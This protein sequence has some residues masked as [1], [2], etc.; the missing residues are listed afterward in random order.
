MFP[1]VPRQPLLR[2]SAVSA[3]LLAAGLLLGSPALHAATGVSTYHIEAGDLDQALQ[4]LQAQGQ[5]KIEYDRKLTAQRRASAVNGQLSAADALRQALAGSGLELRES[6]TGF[7]L[8]RASRTD[9]VTEL[10]AVQIVGRSK[11]DEHPQR[12]A[13][14]VSRVRGE[15]LAELH[16]EDIHDLQ[17]VVPGLYIQSTDSND[18]QLSIRGVGDGGGQSSGDQNIGM[19]SSVATYVDNVYYPRPGIIRSLTDIDYVDVFKGPSGTLFGQNATGGAV[20]IHTKAPSF[21]REGSITTTYAGRNTSKVTGV[22][23]G[24]VNDVT[25]FRVVGFY[26]HSDG[27]VKNLFDGERINGYERSGLRGQWLIRPSNS[28]E[29][30]FTADYGRES[31]NPARVY[32]SVGSAFAASAAKIGATYA[33]GGRETVVDDVTTTE[34]EYGGISAEANWKL[35]NGDKFRSVTAWRRYH[36][37]PQYADELSVPIYANSGTAVGDSVVSQDFRLESPRGEFFDYVAGVNY[38]RDM[39]DTTAHTRYYDTALVTT[40]AGSAFRGLDI[41]RYGHLNDEMAAVYSRGTFHLAERL[42]LQLGAR[43]TYNSRDASFVRKNRASFD[44]GALRIYKTLP[45]AT[46]SLKYQVNDDWSTYAAAGFGQKAGGI[47]VSAGAAKAAGY[48]TLILKPE[49]TTN[50]EIGVL[51][52]LIPDKLTLQADVFR[53]T[54]RD[55]QTQAY[56][57]EALTSYLMNAGTYRS[58]GI[59]VALRAQPLER[60]DVVLSGIINDARYTSYHRALCP[61]EITATYCD[62]TGQ[63]VFNTPKQVFSLQTRYNWEQGSFQPYVSA[64]YSYRGWTY[65]SVDN[66]ASARVPSYGLAAFTIGAKRPGDGGT[67][68]AALWVTNAFNKLYYTRLVGGSTTTGYVGDPRTVGVTLA[69]AFR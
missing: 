51:G 69:Y 23:S 6:D 11:K 17:Y 63:R 44:S 52:T 41:I 62:L 7:T 58:Q 13:T 36:Y 57:D 35:A 18:T 3:A 40:Y 59:E 28:F 22:F 2:L 14:A 64:R 65:G 25:A 45:S 50:V 12:P 42:D 48:D 34:A 5:F 9:N 8:H 66:A 30:K 31:A 29:L 60:L 27:S 37:L 46:A 54:V 38:Y 26:A 39:Q 19:P 53:T 4:A 68:D 56:D 33:A 16:V 1:A 15:S 32:K 24:P 10:D 61:P 49:S 43:A 21:E 67:W 20:D 47:N 55:F